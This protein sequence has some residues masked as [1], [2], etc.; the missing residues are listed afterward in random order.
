[1]VN[2]QLPPCTFSTTECFQW[3]AFILVKRHPLQDFGPE[4]GGGGHLPQVWPILTNLTVLVLV[5]LQTR[6]KKKTGQFSKIVKETSPRKY[7]PAAD[8]SKFQR[9]LILP[10]VWR[11][12]NFT[13]SLKKFSFPFFWNFEKSATGRFSRQMAQSYLLPR[14]DRWGW[15]RHCE[16]NLSFLR[17][18]YWTLQGEKRMENGVENEARLLK[19]IRRLFVTKF[20]H[21]KTDKDMTSFLG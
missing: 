10:G 18:T 1:M 8:H 12:F 2:N 4:M 15:Q 13:G 17:C 21:P 20:M 9:K 6:T 7:T 14:F 3:W 11:N 5:Q 19:P 16:R